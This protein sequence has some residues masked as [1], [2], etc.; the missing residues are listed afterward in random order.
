[1]SFAQVDPA[2]VKPRGLPSSQP[3]VIAARKFLLTIPAEG[4]PTIEEVS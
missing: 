2:T 1:M 3:V 4:A